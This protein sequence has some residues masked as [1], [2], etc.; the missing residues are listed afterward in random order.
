[1]VGTRN[2]PVEQVLACSGR[3]S[4]GVPWF[5]VF[6]NIHVG[7]HSVCMPCR[8]SRCRSAVVFSVEFAEV[9]TRTPSHLVSSCRIPNLTFDRPNWRQLCFSSGKADEHH[10][11]RLYCTVVQVGPRQLREPRLGG[12]GILVEK[13]GD[14]TRRR[15]GTA[16]IRAMGWAMCLLPVP[17]DSN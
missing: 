12:L 8:H 3:M 5:C 9:L 11:Q 15:Q 1:M 6:G 13:R 2:A 17:S 16:S 7:T 10:L 4:H 14:T